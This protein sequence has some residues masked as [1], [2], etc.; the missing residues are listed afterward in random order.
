MSHSEMLKKITQGHDSVPV[1]FIDPDTNRYDKTF[2][3][4]ELRCVWNDISRSSDVPAFADIQGNRSNVYIDLDSLPLVIGSSTTRIE[5]KKGWLVEG[6]PNGFQDIGI[7]NISGS[8]PDN[9]LP[10]II[11]HLSKSELIV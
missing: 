2:T 5:P 8:D 4:A 10:A 9:Q 11:L 7:Y 1:V 6:R 3:G